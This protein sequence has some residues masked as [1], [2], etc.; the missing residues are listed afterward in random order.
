M[1]SD[2]P[3][4]LA[5]EGAEGGRGVPVAPDIKHASDGLKRLA[6]TK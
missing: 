4:P 3:S 2:V 5:G 6:A 1:G